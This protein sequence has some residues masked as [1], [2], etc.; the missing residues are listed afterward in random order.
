M[1]LI[2]RVWL[3]TT[4]T[5]LFAAFVVSITWEAFRNGSSW[6]IVTFGALIAIGVYVIV[7]YM[8]IHPNWQRLKS[9]P[10]KISFTTIITVGLIVGIVHFARFVSSP[11]ATLAL[12]YSVIAAILFLFAGASAYLQTLLFI[13]KKEN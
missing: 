11:E 8:I 9:L 7:V 2:T 6:A 10:M 4:I 5:L 1:N 13:W 12:P 3:S